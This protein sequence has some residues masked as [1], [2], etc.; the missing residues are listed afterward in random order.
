[1]TNR[2][3]HQLTNEVL[4]ALGIAEEGGRDDE[5]ARCVKIV[6][7]ALRIEPNSKALKVCLAKIETKETATRKV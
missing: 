6:Q 5:R 7:R 1:M 3:K 2:L 4:E